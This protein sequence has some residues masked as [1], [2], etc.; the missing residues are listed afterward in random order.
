MPPCTIEELLAA[1]DVP[2][3]IWEGLTN[4]HLLTPL[5]V[6]TDLQSL[7]KKH[8]FDFNKFDTKLVDSI[9]SYSDQGQIYYLPYN[10]LAFA[11]MYNKDIFDKF[12]V[13]YPKDNMTWDEAI[14]LGKKLTRTEAGV[15]YIG[16]RPPG[17]LNR[18]QMQMG[19]PYVDAKTHKA[20]IATDGWKSLFASPNGCQVNIVQ[21]CPLRSTKRP[22]FR[23]WVH[24]PFGTY[25]LKTL[26]HAFLMIRW[27]LTHNKNGGEPQ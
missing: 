26:L 20:T 1:G 2:D 6:P 18:L 21:T 13:P 24:S 22:S 5:K 3:I 14:E 19:V 25:P 10:T 17:A 23:R 12:G 8:G 4:I 16:L 9:K 27:S 15:N 7:A 11:L